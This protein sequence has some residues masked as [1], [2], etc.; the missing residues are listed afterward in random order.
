MSEVEVRVL[1]FGKARE[2]MECEET[3]VTL[4]VSLPYK[5]LKSLFF[6]ELFEELSCIS[7]SCIL[8]V[9]QR[10]ANGD[11]EVHLTPS[12]EVAVIPPLSAKKV[13]T[14]RFGS[15]FHS[16]G[17]ICEHSSDTNVALF[18]MMD[19]A[20]TV[21]VWY[22]GMMPRIDCE[23]TLKLRLALLPFIITF[24][25]FSDNKIPLVFIYHDFQCNGDF[26]V[27]KTTVAKITTY[28]IAVRHMNE[29]RHIPLSYNKG[30]WTLKG[31]RGTLTELID[32]YMA[33]QR[34]ITPSMAVLKNPIPR[35]DFYILHEH[36]TLLKKLGQG[37]FGEVYTGKLRL[38]T[39]EEVSVAVKKVKGDHVK[40]AQLS[41]FVGEAKL[42]RRF[43]H[44]NIV[45]VFGV[46][47]QEEPIMIILE[48]ASGGSLKFSLLLPLEVL[49][50]KFLKYFYVIH[51]DLAARNCL[52][53]S[54]YELKISDFGL[55][56]ADKE[57]M[58]LDKLKSVPIKWLAPETL[59]QVGVFSKK[60][61]VWAFGVLMWEIFARCATDP[62]PGES[63]QKA[64]EYILHRNP[65][66]HP[67]PGTP[68]LIAQVM[69]TCFDRNPETRADFEVVFRLLA[70]DENPPPP[71]TDRA[72]P[73]ENDTSSVPP[74]VELK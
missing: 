64:K 51:R 29:A 25:V 17:N 34:P 68:P 72:T 27:R 31:S 19:K 70:P 40:K 73:S 9:D 28:C 61:D 32:T 41:S 43:D 13:S 4:P 49:Y 5:A 58:K 52:L 22:H 12:S 50:I 56:I 30:Q 33:T 6:D 24:I 44:P 36:V 48:L 10:Y 2:L 53:G 45:R 8:A 15:R 37:A 63:N 14:S 47:V 42:M 7:S 46:A 60:T 39:G 38:K 18:K 20:L 54:K 67:P 69:T 21:N 23:E 59:S 3:K 66:L 71:M 16:S 55:S 35:P 26:L 1:F 57:Q 11:D 65:P 74:I 62:F